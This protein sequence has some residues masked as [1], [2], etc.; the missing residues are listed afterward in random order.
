MCVFF[1]ELQKIQVLLK[2]PAGRLNAGYSQVFQAKR[3]FKI[4][5]V[6]C[7]NLEQKKIIWEV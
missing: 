4:S 1:G 7:Q 2:K 5:R 3:A 6:L